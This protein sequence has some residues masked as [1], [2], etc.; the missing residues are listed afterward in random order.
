MSRENNSGSIPIAISLALLG[1]LVYLDIPLP[2]DLP[3]HEKIVYQTR[4]ATYEPREMSRYE[5][6]KSRESF[7]TKEYKEGLHLKECHLTYT[8]DMEYGSKEYWTEIQKQE[9]YFEQFG[10][11]TLPD[12]TD[13]QEQIEIQ[14]EKQLER[15]DEKMGQR[16]M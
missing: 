6:E 1:A 3:E 12:W 2:I 9:D 4:S 5:F 16:F 13:E 15:R 14:K 11:K 7:K 8:C 10:V